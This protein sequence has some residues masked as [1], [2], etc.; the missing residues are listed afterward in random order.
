MEIVKMKLAE[1]KKPEKNIRMHAE[2]QLRE[3]ERSI[4]MFGQIRP[5]VVD[6]EGTILAGI[7]L[8]ETLV[9]MGKEEADVY[10]LGGMT[11]AQKKKLMI[12]DNKI[13]DLG[14]DNLDV[15]NEFLE[16]LKED[17][18]IPGFD[19]EILHQMV[20]DAEEV[21]ERICEYGK[22]DSEE[23]QEMKQIEERQK[24]AYEKALREDDTQISQDKNRELQDTDNET[25]KSER[26]F[27]I[28]TRCGEKIWL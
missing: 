21:T 6:D 19:E 3:Y 1:M 16:D 10:C 26:N 14:V 12:T 28:C 24:S 8:Y 23:I 18:D 5:I 25:L 17:L 9:R 27:V 13:F 4:R 15:L 11:A 22:L 2:K 20:S 7:G